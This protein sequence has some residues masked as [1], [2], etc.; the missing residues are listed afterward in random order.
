MSEL[1]Q[2]ANEAIN[3]INKTEFL[4]FAAKIKQQ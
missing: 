1:Y 2:G 3:T 4:E